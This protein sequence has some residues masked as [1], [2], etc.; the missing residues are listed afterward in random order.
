V[1]KDVN[2]AYFWTVLARAR[3]DK[4]NKD[5]ASILSSGMTRSHAAVIEQQADTWLQQHLLTWKPAAGH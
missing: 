5:L 3:G 4:E 1:T 2:Q